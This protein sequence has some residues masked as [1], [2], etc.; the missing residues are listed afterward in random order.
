MATI[1]ADLI[2]YIR[3]LVTSVSTD[4]AT[5]AAL[6]E[7]FVQH[8]DED[9]FAAILSRHGSSIMRLARRVLGD[10]HAAED[11]FQ[12]TFL[13]LARKAAVL[14]KDRSLG[15]WLYTVAR[16]TALKAKAGAARRR[17]HERQVAPM[18]ATQPATDSSRRELFPILDAELGALP[19]KLRAPLV[20]CYLQGKTNEEA[21]RELGCAAGTL[22]WRLGRARDLLRDGTCA[23][24]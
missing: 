13:I 7:G 19:E 10:M 4:P 18:R 2:Q 11:V 1:P 17:D 9:A 3:R 6:L 22:K 24:A 21:A 16:N 12:A 15:N 14:E 8:R 23:R 20:L 5:D